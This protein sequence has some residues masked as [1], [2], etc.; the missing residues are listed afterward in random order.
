VKTEP[1]KL[2]LPVKSL[3]LPWWYWI[4]NLVMTVVVIL[5]W[6]VLVGPGHP[7]FGLTVVV[8]T[9]GLSPG[10]AGPAMRILPSNWFHVPNGERIFHRVLGVGSFEWLLEHS[11][12]NHHI[13]RPLRGFA[14]KCRRAWR[15]LCHPHHFGDPRHIFRVLMGRRIMDTVAWC[16]RSSLSGAAT[17]LHHASNPTSVI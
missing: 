4:A 11:T 6:F 8:W 2:S 12:Y 17:A 16:R 9:F 13:A 7:L 15:M 5:T 1:T 3:C 14:S 10:I